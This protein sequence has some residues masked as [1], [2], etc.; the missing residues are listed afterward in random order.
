M[1]H[2]PTK[3][4]RDQMESAGKLC[5]A[6]LRSGGKCRQFAGTRTD[7]P[8]VSS[9]WLHLGRSTNVNKAAIKQEIA[10]RLA[11]EATFGDAKDVTP[12]E[13]LAGLLHA[14]SAHVGWLAGTLAS[15][16]KEELGSPYGMQ[17]I[18]SYGVERD[19]LG[20][21]AKLCSDAHVDERLVALRETQT[22]LLGEALK[23]ACLAIGMEQTQQLKLG[24]PLRS[25]LAVLE[26]EPVSVNHKVLGA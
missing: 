4:H 10:Q 13:A 5:G 2:K 18:H 3:A 22:R 6:K 19:R 20:Q 15:L 1:A 21:V 16:S 7:H 26:V 11:Q 25:Q 23:A 8:G 24:A 14:T 9:C 12:P 17:I